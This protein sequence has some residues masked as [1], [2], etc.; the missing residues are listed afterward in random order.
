MSDQALAGPLPQARSARGGTVGIICGGGVLPAAVAEAVLR[1][2]RDVYLLPIKGWADS[3]SVARYRHDWIKLGQF[4]RLRTLARNAG[5]SEVVFI[6]N[7]LRPSLSMLRLDWSTL[8]LLPRAL[9]ALRGGDDRVLSRMARVFEEH[10]FRVVGAHELAPDILV[11]EGVLGRVAPS[12]RQWDDALRGL[13]LIDAIGRFDIGQAVVVAD[14]HV[15]A[16]EAAEGT[17]AMLM[18][19]ADLRREGRVRT[20]PGAGVLVKA[21]KPQQDRRVD[22]PAIGPQ[23]VEH[24]K[25]AGL[26]GLAVRAGEVIVAEP[27]AVVSAA[28][29]AG[30]FVIGVAAG[31]AS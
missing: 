31:A 30:L 24:V 18:R 29:A 13:D 3:A 19:I 6:G 20:A 14:N 5:C 7:V 26:G 16:V 10:G 4:G 17:D 21:P 1:A 27:E 25:R 28:D 2:G 12:A 8:R 15:L 11:P 22:M 9:D 23:T